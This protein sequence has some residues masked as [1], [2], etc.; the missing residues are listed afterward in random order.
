MNQ[1]IDQYNHKG[2]AIVVARSGVSA[3]FVSFW[4]EPIFVTDGFLI[5]PKDENI[6][7]D[8][9]YYLIKYHE[10]ELMGLQGGVANPHVTPKIIGAIETVLLTRKT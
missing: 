9:L 10:N 2:K 7:I 6:S 8:F 4:N 3:G 1:Y 5:E